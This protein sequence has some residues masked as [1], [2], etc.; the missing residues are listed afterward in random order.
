MQ[1]LSEKAIESALNGNWQEAVD[2]NLNLLKIDRNNIEALNRL[3]YAYTK[4]NMISQAKKTYKKVLDQDKYN[5]IAKR[6]IKKLKTKVTVKSSKQTTSNSSA[7]PRTSFLEEPGK[8]KTTQLVRLADSSTISQLNIG[9]TVNLEP[10]KRTVLVKTQENTY[11][12]SL[13]DDLSM[14]LGK[15]MRV[16]NKYEVFL[17]SIEGNAVQIFIIEKKRSKR[18]KNIPSFPT[19]AT[20]SYYADIRHAHLDEEP[21]D[22]R[23]TGQEEE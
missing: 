14:R 4:L 9:Q 17:R 12:G 5:P 20:S 7:F 1:N 11:I 18:T 6:N 8:T 22:T 16:G 10:R 13:P 23:E 21:V 3:G 19:K 2:L 15:L